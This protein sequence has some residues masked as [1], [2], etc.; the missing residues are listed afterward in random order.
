MTWF[1]VNRCE[2]LNVRCKNKQYENENV[3]PNFSLVLYYMY[4]FCTTFL[5]SSLVVHGLVCSRLLITCRFLHTAPQQTHTHTQL[6][7]V[8]QHQ[9]NMFSK[10]K[11]LLTTA[12]KPV[13]AHWPDVGVRRVVCTRTLSCQ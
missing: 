7:N 5:D 13:R 9:F 4:E 2:T 1:A 12:N 8:G 10:K 6:L 3:C 11:L